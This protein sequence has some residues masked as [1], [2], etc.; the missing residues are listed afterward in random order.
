MEVAAHLFASKGFKNTNIAEIAR[1][2]GAAEGTIFYHFKTKEELFL[3]ILREFR[4]SI[5]RDFS[6]FEKS[7]HLGS[8]LGKAEHLISFYLS[9]SV[10][11]EEKFL[12]L[13]RHDAYELSEVNPLFR[14]ELEAIYTCFVDVFDAVIAE[15]QRDGSI[16]EE[17]TPRKVA[18]ILFALVD[19]VSRLNTYRLYDAESLFKELLMSC[20]RILR[21]STR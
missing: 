6:D 20:K 11:M 12:L 21:K 4:G 8:G 9:Y 10:S 17:I 5:I 7:G 19:S 3:A 2:T 1:N 14:E 13:H 18:M 15:G 16:S